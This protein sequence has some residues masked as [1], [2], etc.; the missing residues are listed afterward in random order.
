M[1][2]DH[3]QDMIHIKE[4][5]WQLR[6]GPAAV[7]M[8]RDVT[9]KLLESCI[10]NMEDLNVIEEYA[11]QLGWHPDMNTTAAIWLSSEAMRAKVDGPVF[12]SGRMEGRD[13]V[14]VMVRKIV[15]P[16]DTEHLSLDGVLKKIAELKENFKKAG[17]EIADL[18]HPEF[19]EMGRL[20]EEIHEL[21]KKV[22]HW[23]QARES[24]MAAG[25]IMK[26]QLDSLKE[27]YEVMRQDVVKLRDCASKVIGDGGPD[28]DAYLD[29]HVELPTVELKKEVE[30]LTFYK[31]EVYQCLGAGSDDVNKFIRDAYVKE[32]G[33]GGVP[34][35]LRK[36]YLDY[37]ADHGRG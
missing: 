2:D 1:S 36:E 7:G 24:A 10:A 20:Q 12:N 6:E 22:T 18:A 34:E 9:V 35:K 33:I 13:D 16:E 32:K 25:D 5:L 11:K 30:W 23:R 8:K 14:K 31:R 28:L 3:K 15:D 19:G 4:L 21:K 26:A 29:G 17:D 27:E 37:E